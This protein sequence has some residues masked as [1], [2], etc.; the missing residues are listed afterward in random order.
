MNEKSPRS[1]ILWYFLAL[2]LVSILFLGWLLRPFV[3]ILVLAAVV[4]G[5]FAPVYQVL[6]KVEYILKPKLVGNRIKM[7][8]LI[9]FLSIIGG[10]SVFG[11]IGIIY[12]PLAAT[13]FLTLT[14]IYRA[15]YQRILNPDALCPSPEAKTGK[16]NIL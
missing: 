13:G 6:I 14:E 2:F 9:V 3:P 1:I 12:G 5:V 8:T 10:L 7:H 15:N 16:V 11:L 4:T